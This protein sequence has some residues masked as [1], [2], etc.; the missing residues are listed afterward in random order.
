MRILVTGGLGVNGVWVMRELVD[1]GDEP[2]ALEVR[3]DFSL[4]PDLEGRVEVVAGDVTDLRGLVST[5]KDRGVDCIAH[6]AIL[7]PGDPDVYRGFATNAMGTVNVLE[8][9]RLGGVPRVVLT[10]SKAVYAPFDGPHGPP[11]YEPVS[12]RHPVAPLPAMR[13]YSASKILGESAGIQ[14]AASFGMEFLALRFATIYGPGKK[15]RHGP[16]GIHSRIIEN[17]LMNQPTTIERGGDEADDMVYVKDVAHSIVLACTVPAPA[18]R[19]F[20]VGTG[21]ASTLHDFAEAVEAAVPGADIRVGGGL[22]YLGFGRIYGRMDIGR[23][24]EQLGYEPRYDLSAGV[25]DYV[26][27]TR[28]LDLETTVQRDQSRW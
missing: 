15:A 5:L 12:E 3:R 11:S 9:A 26:D 20:N 13:V 24:R 2:I 1:R 22:D 7:S 23:A 6:L 16:V 4:A 14:Y 27:E 28:K 8:A 17:A 19:V 18:D 10:S 21:T 25:R